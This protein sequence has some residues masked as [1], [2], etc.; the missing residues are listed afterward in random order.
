MFLM[1][2]IWQLRAAV[3]TLVG[4]L[5]VHH[6]R[7]LFASA[8]HSNELSTAHRYLVWLAPI[9]AVLVLLAV[10]QV[11]VH[12]SRLHDQEAEQLPDFGPLWVLLASTLLTAFVAQE[13]LETLFA[14]GYIPQLAEL[15]GGG[16]W[17]AIPLAVA[18]AGGIALLLRGA[19]TVVQWAAA[20]RHRSS[21]SAA[22]RVALPALDVLVPT[23]SLLGRRL[24]SRGPPLLS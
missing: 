1:P 21:R 23:Q 9:T 24:A 8:A 4:I 14:H 5:A 15:F 10:L 18:S 19:A 16:G 13:S 2:R 7:F 6:G 11:A 3:L 20:R 22:V 17:T 12:A